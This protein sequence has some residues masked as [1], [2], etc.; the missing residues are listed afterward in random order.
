MKKTTTAPATTKR[1]KRT[2]AEIMRDQVE[3]GLKKLQAA[4]EVVEKRAQGHLDNLNKAKEEL[5][6]V[7][8]AI[9]L[10]TAALGLP[11]TAPKE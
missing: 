8:Q 11:A 4:R 2:T 5:A 3:A 1:A 9:A 10:A 6:L 7:D